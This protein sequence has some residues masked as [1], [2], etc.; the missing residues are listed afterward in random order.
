MALKK[1]IAIVVDGPS[2]TLEDPAPPLA[3]VSSE[4]PAGFFTFGY[5]AMKYLVIKAYKGKMK[6][7]EA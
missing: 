3:K 7:F 6:Y 1:K 4:I 2:D 5:I